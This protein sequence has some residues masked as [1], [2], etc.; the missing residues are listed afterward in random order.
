MMIMTLIPH[1]IMMTVMTPAASDR[2][3]LPTV[4]C[5]E[6]GLQD[7]TGLTSP[8]TAL[9]NPTMASRPTNTSRLLVKAG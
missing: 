9:T 8:S 4:A 3:Q 2:T 1:T 6:I 7:I 5:G